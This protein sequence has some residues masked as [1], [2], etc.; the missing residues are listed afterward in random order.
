[1]KKRTRYTL[2]KP[3]DYRMVIFL[4]LLCVFLIL[5]ILYTQGKMRI[6]QDFIARQ[7]T[8]EED[9]IQGEV[10]DTPE[11]MP[12][13][14]DLRIVLMDRDKDIYRGSISLYGDSNLTI[15][16]AGQTSDL[17]AGT[18]YSMSA[19]QISAGETIT[20]TGAEGSQW[21]LVNEDGV[22]SNGYEGTLEIWGQANG[23]VL[24]NQI[25][26]EYY[27]KRVVPSEMP[28]TYGAEALKAQAVCARTY[29]YGHSNSYAY[30]DVKGNMDD[31]VSFQVYNQ[32]TE[33]AETNEAIRSTAGQI[34]MKDGT[35]VDALYYSTSCG[36][37]QDGTLFGNMDSSIFHT[38]YIGLQ[39]SGQDFD[40]YLRSGD[41]HAYE[42]NERYFRWQASLTGDDLSGL[43]AHLQNYLATDDSISCDRKMK[44]KITD[45]S[46]T[47]DKALGQIKNITVEK[48]NPGG[49]A[50]CI[51]ISFSE[52]KVE[53]EDQLH[54]RQILGDLCGYVILQ[55]QERLDSV[56]TLPSAAISIEKQGDGKFLV[57]G[58]GFGHG[59]GMSQNAAKALAAAG[60]AYTDILGYFYQG[61]A[62]Q[63][64][65]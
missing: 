35:V 51:S 31:T 16:R 50:M 6:L 53:I 61:T 64:V 30:P 10:P 47:D 39:E 37:M 18:T 27:L 38:G 9:K 48:R 41:E 7:T 46:L 62:L 19:D 44:K 60:Y 52:G 23:L 14:S 43:R 33:S 57:Y 13:S 45:T 22:T 29:A 5:L 36:Y 28:R 8:K 25:P 17:A 55:D 58:G 59:V 32:G 54:I 34:L 20:V 26:M 1:M 49:A 12:Y 42:A 15:N 65:Y 24:V 63:Q 2:R 3:K 11:A 4:T 56:S 21:Y 40:T